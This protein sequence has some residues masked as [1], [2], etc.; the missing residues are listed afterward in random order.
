[1]DRS[2]TESLGPP[3]NA[4]ARYTA[5]VRAVSAVTNGTND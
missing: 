4:F 5:T 2:L 1:M 3:R